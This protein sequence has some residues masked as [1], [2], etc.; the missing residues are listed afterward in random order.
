MTDNEKFEE[1]IKLQKEKESDWTKTCITATSTM[2]GILIALTD[3]KNES[4]A[5][6]Y[7]FV[8]TISSLGLCTLCGL[9]YLYSYSDTAHRLVVKYL[10]LTDNLSQKP[11]KVVAVESH[12]IFYYLEKLFFVFLVCSFITIVLYG[13]STRIE[14]CP[15]DTSLPK[16]NL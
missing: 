1:K 10:E 8:S 2:I 16:G 7:L 11:P 13:I 9:L 3:G 14:F 5:T 15:S 6:K 12:K 4:I